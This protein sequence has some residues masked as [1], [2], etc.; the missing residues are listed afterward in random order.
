MDKPGEVHV[1][2]ENPGEP[3][4]VALMQARELFR[5]SDDDGEM[6]RSYL[7]VKKRAQRGPQTRL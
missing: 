1:I 6:A 2:G 5:L 7:L 4:L 3:S